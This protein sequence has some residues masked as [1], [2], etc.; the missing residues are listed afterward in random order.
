MP[1]YQGIS[2]FKELVI[3]GAYQQFKFLIILFRDE[4]NDIGLIKIHLN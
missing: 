4:R 3:F 1:N 2:I